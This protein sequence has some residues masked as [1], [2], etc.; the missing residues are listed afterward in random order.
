MSEVARR[1]RL[2]ALLAVV[3]GRTF[4][5]GLEMVGGPALSEVTGR[6]RRG[7]RQQSI[8]NRRPKA[9]RSPAV[10]PDSDQLLYLLG[11]CEK[12]RGRA[13]AAARA[14]DRI[15]PNSTFAPG[16]SSGE[17][18]LLV[19]RGRFADAEELIHEMLKFPQV[20]GIVLGPV[21]HQQGRIDEAERLIEA[22]LAA[23]RQDGG[24]GIRRG[25][26]PGQ[27]LYRDPQDHTPSRRGP[28]RSR[29]GRHVRL[30]TTIAS[31]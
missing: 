18:E 6:D 21:F 11:L 19:D 20:D 4:R 27:T 16:R 5:R 24:R 22:A 9:G 23:P 29:S 10:W 17:R 8:W 12:Q 15:P 13:D 2:V 31:G 1:W 28:G 7:S 3:G 25:D 30:P 26:Q 14:W